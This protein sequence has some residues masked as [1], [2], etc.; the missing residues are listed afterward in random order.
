MHVIVDV[1]GFL[2]TS[3]M[4][5]EEDRKKKNKKI[6]F[7][8]EEGGGRPAEAAHLLEGSLTLLRIHVGGFLRAD[9]KRASNPVRRFCSSS[10]AEYPP[11]DSRT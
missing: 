10:E 4:T 6:F 8:S 7:E 2:L 1:D 5:E 9:L 3:R 11:N